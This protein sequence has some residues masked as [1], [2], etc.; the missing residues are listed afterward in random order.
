VADRAVLH[1]VSYDIAD[2][3][4]RRRIAG[5]LEERAAR[6]QES[7][8]ELRITSAVARALMAELVALTGAE[9]SVRIY[10]VPDAALPRCK[11]H[12]GPAIAGGGRFWLM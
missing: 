6:V 3:K 1:L 2:N 12:G 9:D 4:R 11:V 5:V 8:F 10:A 7:L